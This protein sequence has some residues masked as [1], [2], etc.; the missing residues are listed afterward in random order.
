MNQETIKGW[1]DNTYE[2]KGLN[3]LRP[4]D[5][6]Y[7]FLELL[8]VESGKKFLDVACGPG[9]MLKVAKEYGLDISG[10]DISD[11]AIEMAKKSL[12]DASLHAVNAEELPFADNTFDYITC[13]G[14]LERM[15]DTKKTIQEQIRVAKPTAR[16][17]YMV[18][19][20]ER[21]SWKII[22][23][24]L[25]I[26]NKKG[27]Q[28]A[29]SMKEWSDLFTSLGLKIEDV[30]HDQWP[31]T[32]WKRWLTLNSRL[33]RIDFKKIQAKRVPMEG[34]YEFIFILSKI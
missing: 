3:Y 6:Y 12:P 17:C 9:Q 16:I 27:H 10:I 19:N 4:T 13:L 2:T 5:A 22:K 15:L 34:A 21:V 7:I 18:R 29:K 23:N 20:S 14:S 11:V 31:S 30:H 33:V 24:S 26:I 28:G 8:K 25:G 1:F 32:R